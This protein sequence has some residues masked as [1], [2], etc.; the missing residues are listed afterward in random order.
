M[1]RGRVEL[2]RIENKVNQQVTF[3]KR[4]SGLLKKAREISLLCDADV[5]LVIFSTKGKLFEYATDSCMDRILE[6]YQAHVGVDRPTRASDH[7]E[8]PRSCSLEHAKV[9]ARMEALQRNERNIMGDD[10]DSLTLREL[11]NLEHQVCGSLKRIRSR[12]NQQMHEAI[13]ELQKQDKAL[14]DQNN[15]LARKKKE[16]ETESSSATP[17]EQNNSRPSCF[18]LLQPMNTLNFSET[19]EA[20]SS[21]AEQ[22]EGTTIPLQN[23]PSDL[24]LV[25]WMLHRSGE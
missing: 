13:S 23:Q 5:G 25:P 17:E 6:R 9:K 1:G 18:D 14:Q 19:V 12:M 4:R 7:L 22:V 8:S 20:Q 3:S 16:K 2:K 11:Q 24:E 21:S 15:L 10:L